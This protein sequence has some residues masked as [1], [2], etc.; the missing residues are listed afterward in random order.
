MFEPLQTIARARI[1]LLLQGL[2]LDLEL[3]DAAIEFVEF[4]GLRIDGHAQPRTGLV[5][6]VDRLVRQKPVGDVSVG[7]GCGGDDRRVV[8][9]H[10]MVQLVF[11]L[12]PAQDRNRV[13][14]RRLAD[15][16]R[17]KAAFECGVLL[18]V[19]AVLVEG[20]GADAMQ[21]AARQRRLQHVRG[22]HRPFRLAGAD[23]G[24]QFVDEQD[25]LAGARGDLGQHRFQ[26]L[27]ELAAVFGAGQQAAQIE[28]QQLF[29][30]QAFR[31]V[32]VDDAQRQP[33]DDRGLADTRLADQH[34]VVL[35][36]AR[37]H[38]D[39]APDLLVAADDRIELALARRLGQVAGVFL[40]RII[41]FLGRGAV[42][43]APLAH[44]LDSPVEALRIDPGGRQCLGR[45][46]AGC[47]RQGEQQPFDRDK[48][49]AR[50]LRQLFG[51]FEDSRQLGRHVDLA[52]TRAF[53]PRQPVQLG[54]DGGQSRLRVAP[55]RADQV[56]AQAFRIFE[57]H[58]QQMFR[59]QPLMAAPQ[60]QSLRRLQ[61]PLGAVG[62]FLEFHPRSP[63]RLGRNDRVSAGARR[64]T[65]HPWALCSL[66][67]R[68]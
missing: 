2:A 62:I 10:A 36:P 25:D 46:G 42:G 38:L 22:V 45:A 20:R 27:L 5:H 65:A 43:L 14:D 11:L 55:G 60:R 30:L 24:V 58:L 52:G 67:D 12:D 68:A 54:V 41:A 21:F 8:D 51:L 9:P 48:A 32:A 26:P 28:R 16:D 59:R 37:Q 13:L 6:Q 4:L 18:D 50:F 44:L 64:D 47:R 39:R 17:L 57:Q 61:K 3:D 7:Q 29:V 35:G 19:L 53:D 33:F 15:I 23:Q 49:V 63:P 34:R 1:G 40:Q 66:C 31:H 56:G